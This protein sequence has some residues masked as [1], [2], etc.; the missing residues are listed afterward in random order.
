VDVGEL[1][2]VASSRG[3]VHAPWRGIPLR[4]APSGDA[5]P[6]SRTCVLH[7]RRLPVRFLSRLPENPEFMDLAAP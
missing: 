1:I 7:N 2:A 6:R 4:W 3:V 5:I